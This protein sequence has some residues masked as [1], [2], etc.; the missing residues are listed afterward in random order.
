MG[1]LAILPAIIIVTAVVLVII[2]FIVSKI[3]NTKEGD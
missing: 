1:V 3:F 2:F